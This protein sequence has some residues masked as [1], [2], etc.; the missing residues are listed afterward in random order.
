MRCTFSIL[1]FLTLAALLASGTAA[2]AYIGPIIVIGAVG[3]RCGW[4]AAIAA[5]ALIV[6]SYPFYLLYRRK[7][8]RKQSKS[9]EVAPPPHPTET[10]EAAVSE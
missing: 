3:S 6:L 1:S 10:P 9:Q 4:V 5:A 8:G 2:H 7:N